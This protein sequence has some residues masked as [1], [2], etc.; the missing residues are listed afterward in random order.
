MVDYRNIKVPNG[1]INEIEKI[2]EEREG[3]GYRNPSEFI[4]DALRRRIE[5][6]SKDSS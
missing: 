5:E 3:L 1:M 4:M 6:L 2:I